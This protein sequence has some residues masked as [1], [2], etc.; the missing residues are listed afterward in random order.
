MGRRDHSHYIDDGETGRTRAAGGVDDHLDLVD[1][2][3]DVEV[4]DLLADRFGD[5]AVDRSGEVDDPV[6][7]ETGVLCFLIVVCC[8]GVCLPKVLIDSGVHPGSVGNG[9]LQ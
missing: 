8:H 1:L 6:I 3:L 5:T 9:Q 4:D 2:A 7:L